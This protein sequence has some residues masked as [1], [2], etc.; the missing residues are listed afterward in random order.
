M[1]PAVAS[2]LAAK[3]MARKKKSLASQ[4]LQRNSGLTW[5]FLGSMV[6]KLVPEHSDD[7]SEFHPLETNIWLY[8]YNIQ[9]NNKKVQIIES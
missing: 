2:K 6:L 8:S 5:T 1:F 7:S 9:E 4:E 3:I